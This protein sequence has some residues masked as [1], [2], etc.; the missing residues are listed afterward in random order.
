MHLHT[1]VL[2]WRQIHNAARHAGAEI[3]D[4]DQSGSRI[5][6][7]KF[8]VHL[9]GNSKR[10]PNRRGNHTGY[11]ATWDQWGVFFGYLYDLDPKMVCGSGLKYALYRNANDFH[12]Q[13]SGRFR[14][15]S[16]LGEA[17]TFVEV[18][19]GETVSHWPVDSHGDHTW[20]YSAA[21]ASCIKCSATRRPQ[22]VVP[23]AG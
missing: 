7:R 19:Q 14:G 2:T 10:R 23:I 1:N 16:V 6:E 11:A 20:A 9:E 4:L 3:M 5:A 12:I 15:R 8:V 17:R 21:G 18:P 13:T 22:S